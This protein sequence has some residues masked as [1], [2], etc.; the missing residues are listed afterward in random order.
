MYGIRL[1]RDRG[2][3]AFAT[4]PDRMLY[5]TMLSLRTYLLDYAVLP[6][7]R[8][9]TGVGGKFFTAVLLFVITV[10]VFRTRAES[11]LFALPV[12]VFALLSRTEAVKKMVSCRQ[13]LRI[14]LTALSAMLCSFFTLSILLKEPLQ[15]FSLII[16]AFGHESVNGP[17]YILGAMQDSTYLLIVM[18]VLFVLYP[19]AYLRKPI[20]R[21]VSER[22]Q[23]V[24]SII[25]T[26]LLFGGFL[27]SLIYFMPQFPLYAE[28][29]Y[30]IYRM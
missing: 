24:L 22:T 16:A 25:S 9:W 4:T 11:L 12:L 13:P 1:P 6:L 19:L 28:Y 15:I 30:G 18:A 23:M 27:I 2:N 26:A 7:R 29:A 5:G 10:L 20:R 3:A 14:L 8:K 21:K 17:F